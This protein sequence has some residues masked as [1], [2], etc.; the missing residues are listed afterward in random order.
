MP[1]T[2]KNTISENMEN[3]TLKKTAAKGIDI[4]NENKTIETVDTRKSVPTNIK[5]L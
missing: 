1:K 3:C 4:R 2:H 5:K